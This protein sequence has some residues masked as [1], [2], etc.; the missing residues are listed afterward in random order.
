[1]SLSSVLSTNLN[2]AAA[3]VWRGVILYLHARLKIAICASKD[4]RGGVDGIVY[5]DV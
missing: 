5:V 1:M 3:S 4:S 2:C